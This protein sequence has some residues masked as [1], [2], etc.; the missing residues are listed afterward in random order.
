LCHHPSS[1]PNP[2]T[3]HYIADKQTFTLQKHTPKPPSHY[4]HRGT[5][6]SSNPDKH[7]PRAL[8]PRHGRYAGTLIPP[9]PGKRN[10]ARK[11]WLPHCTDPGR[12]TSCRERFARIHSQNLQNVCKLFIQS[13]SSLTFGA[14]KN[15]IFYHCFRVERME[16]VPRCRNP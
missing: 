8:T 5:H 16:I 13:F 11:L 4:V 15:V 14:P 3:P 6:Q 12:L 7:F 10:K 1:L 9:Q 2:L